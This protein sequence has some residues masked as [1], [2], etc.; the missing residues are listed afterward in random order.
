MALQFAK[1]WL[2]SLLVLIPVYWMIWLQR[3]KPSLPKLPF[4]SMAILAR[5]GKDSAFWKYLYPV[6]RSL[7]MLCL[8]IAIA[9]PRWGRGVRD[10]RLRGVDIVLAMDISGSM[11]FLDFGSGSRLQAAVKVAQDFVSRRTNDRFGLVAFS[12]YA[13][14]QI[15]LTYD[16]LALNEQLASMAVNEDASGTAIGLGL[17]KAVG[18]LRS[19]KAKSR[20]VILITDGVSNT[21]EI[22]PIT[23]A[24]MAKAFGIRVYPIG[25]GGDANSL[26]PFDDPFF[27]K[28]PFNVQMEL[29]METLDK[30]ASI[31]GTGQAARAT[32][33]AQLEDI[34]DRIDLLEKTD[35]QV[36]LRYH[37]SEKFMVLLWCA[38]GLMII[39]LLFRLYFKPVLPE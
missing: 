11:S 30:I 36:R 22:D 31:T 18:R 26:I 28:L 33:P 15:P 25:V 14:T 27:G 13:L 21:G 10:Y 6:L 20:V 9:Q 17:A 3:Q 34:M 2:L 16:R 7:T 1:P 37:W 32:D 35:Y 24:D 5:V 12:E 8:I 29:D 4:S 23:A 39:E 19:S 38:V